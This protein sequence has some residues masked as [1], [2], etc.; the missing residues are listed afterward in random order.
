MWPKA[1]APQSRWASRSCRCLSCF[2]L[3]NAGKVFAIS[4]PCG[5]GSA[6][7]NSTWQTEWLLANGGR[8]SPL[9]P[10]PAFGS[11]APRSREARALTE[12]SSCRRL[13]PAAG[14]SV[15][16][17]PSS[18]TRLLYSLLYLFRSNVFDILS[19]A[20]ASFNFSSPFSIS[21]HLCL[22]LG[23]VLSCV[24]SQSPFSLH[25]FSFVVSPVQW[26]FF[27]SIIIILPLNIPFLKICQFI[28]NSFVL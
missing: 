2:P 4:G 8:S 26:F 13:F 24:V 23:K 27:I 7:G 3:G 28:P 17:F 25:L 15:V 19:L 10:G 9:L 1:G 18:V 22:P 16:L 6:P 14:N 11:R 5:I 20:S 21:K 12:C